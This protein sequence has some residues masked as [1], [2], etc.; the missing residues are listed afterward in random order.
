MN[1][2]LGLRCADDSVCEPPRIGV[3]LPVPET[4]RSIGEPHSSRKYRPWVYF[5]ACARP[6][7]LWGIA[8]RWIWFDMRQYPMRATP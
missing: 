6:S 8:I 5:S 7:T 3:E 1:L 4:P 2:F